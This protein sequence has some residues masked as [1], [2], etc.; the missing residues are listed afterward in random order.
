MSAVRTKGLLANVGISSD[1]TKGLLAEAGISSD[2]YNTDYY[3]WTQKIKQMLESRAYEQLDVDNLI[4]EV[5]DMG[6]NVRRGLRSHLANLLMHLLKWQY[7]SHIHSHDL[8]D[9]ERWR[10]VQRHIGVVEQDGAVGQRDPHCTGQTVVVGC[11]G[12]DVA[13]QR[14]V[15]SH[16]EGQACRRLV[17]GDAFLR[18]R[19][20]QLVVEELLLTTGGTG[21]QNLAQLRPA[22][23][24]AKRAG[25]GACRVDAGGRGVVA[26]QRKGGAADAGSAHDLVG[27]ARPAA[28]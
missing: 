19:F 25:A 12:Q 14:W 9:R 28:G 10:L 3:A 1:S 23:D 18:I 17:G 2:L 26:F 22:G 16:R 6:K 5:S 4:E 7:Q 27:Q 20:Q 13:R 15:I 11:R 8:V 24:L 21:G